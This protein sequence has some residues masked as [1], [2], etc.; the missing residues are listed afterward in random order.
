MV[1]RSFGISPSQL[2]EWVED[3]KAKMELEM[4]LERE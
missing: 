4:E 3:A 1:I 2:D